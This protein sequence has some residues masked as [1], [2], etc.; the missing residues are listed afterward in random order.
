MTKILK[1]TPVSGSRMLKS[2]F[3]ESVVEQSKEPLTTDEYVPASVTE[4]QDSMA[5]QFSEE[6][7]PESGELEFY[8]VGDVVAAKETAEVENEL[9]KKDSEIEALKF[10]LENAK[11][12]IANQ[13]KALLDAQ[14]DIE[15]A[16]SE[17][18][19]QGHQ[20]GLEE[21]RALVKGDYE[22]QAQE[23]EKVLSE[24]SEKVQVKLS[25]THEIAAEIAFAAICRFVSQNYQD[26]TFI[27]SSIEKTVSQVRD[28]L[29]LKVHINEE[30]FRV[31]AESVSGV[32]LKDNS[33]KIEWIPDPRVSVGGC[34]VETSG[35][36][37][38][39]RLET[40]LQRLKEAFVLVNRDK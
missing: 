4:N 26:E 34:L 15:N 37:W 23:I 22:R 33:Q 1:S 18:I 2:R 31:L 28:S 21:A 8:S 11:Q 39:G 13:E 16:K 29:E 12:E 10:E 17:A 19:K 7:S 25:D 24:L 32:H 14:A 20:E 6:K 5:E 38:D 36:T 3:E 40:Q 27:R 30:Q 9:A 35:G